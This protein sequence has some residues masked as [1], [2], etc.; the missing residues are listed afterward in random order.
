MSSVME[1]SSVTA[2]K[3]KAEG[4]DRAAIITAIVIGII[5]VIVVRISV[6]G[7]RRGRIRDH[8]G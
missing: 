2:S 4:Y 1:M 7:R 5:R 8:I 6:I 3:S